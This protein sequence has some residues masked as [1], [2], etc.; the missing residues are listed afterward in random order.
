MENALLSFLCGDIHEEVTAEVTTKAIKLFNDTYPDFMKCL[1]TGV[2]FSECDYSK[3]SIADREDLYNILK[4]M[5]VPL[6]EIN[7][8]F[9]V[10]A[11]IRNDSIQKLELYAD[12][13]DKN[14][15]YNNISQ[16]AGSTT[17]IVGGSLAIAAA[18]AAGV[19]TG[20]ASLIAGS[21]GCTLSI[22]AIMSY[23]G[24]NNVIKFRMQSHLEEDERLTHQLEKQ[25]QDLNEYICQLKKW[26]QRQHMPFINITSCGRPTSSTNV[27][28]EGLSTQ[29]TRT[30]QRVV[31]I[32][33][34]T[35]TD[36]LISLRGV[37]MVIDVTVIGVDV[38]DLIKGSRSVTGSWFRE[39]SEKL[40]HELN[41]MGTIY[42]KIKKADENKRLQGENAA[43]EDENVKLQA[44]VE[45]LSRQLA[46]KNDC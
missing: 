9:N 25:L 22:G 4:R 37:V 30:S 27:I 41:K 44:E 6:N 35:S 42:E 2:P 26:H 15:M 11:S 28:S 8:S 34:T 7:E 32:P 31:N 39:S 17:G 1:M 16:I 19:S 24:Y 46:A 10:W 33:S 43:K 12:E 36:P 20:G 45:E 14:S 5:A 23:I 29:N 40:K 38:V 13:L 18:A 3:T 21:I